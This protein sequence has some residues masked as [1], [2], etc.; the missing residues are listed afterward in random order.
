MTSSGKDGSSALVWVIYVT[1]GTGA[2]AEL[3][4]YRAIPDD[5]GQLKE[6]FSAPLGIGAK[7]SSVATEKGRVYVGTRDGHVLGFGAPTTAAVGAKGTDLGTAKVGTAAAGTVTVTASRNVTIN[8]I[9][10]S[11]PFKIG[12]SLTLP[13]KVS[14]GASL[15]VPVTFSPTAWG[16]VD[17]TLT[18]KTADGETVLLGVHGVGT[19][20]GLGA[21]PATVQFTDV[22]TKTSSRATANIVNTGTTAVKITRVTLPANAALKVDAG[23]APVVGQTIQP[24]ASIPVSL[25][26]S[27]TTAN[28][29]TDSLAVVSDRGGVTVKI[30]ATAV[31]GTAH[32]EVPRSLDFGDV[33][34]GTSVTRAFPIKNTGNVPMTITKA[35]APNG[36]LLD[37]D[38]HLRGF[39]N[40]RRRNRVPDRDL[41]AY[42]GR[43]S[44][45]ERDLLPPHRGRRSGR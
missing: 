11:A 42:G 44:R 13:R 26:F 2:G 8:S 6:V 27:P 23:T 10:T 3:R 18:V 25:T 41:R 22:P 45:N 4:A 21:T 29:I 38:S 12:T 28:P 30:T 32:L 40:S 5:N 20:D 19:K 9:T 33:P 1:G 16:Q 15:A 34:A 14:K 35:K 43:A 31:S 39:E 24:L 7:F 17:G 36:G 37:D